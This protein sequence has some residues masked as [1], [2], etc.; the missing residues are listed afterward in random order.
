M[1]L[2]KHNHPKTLYLSHIF[3][4]KLTTYT[5]Q[6]ALYCRLRII[7]NQVAFTK[8]SLQITT[9]QFE[10]PS[11]INHITL[12]LPRFSVF[13]YF[14]ANTFSLKSTSKAFSISCFECG[15]SDSNQF[16]PIIAIPPVKKSTTISIGTT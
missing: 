8:L 11:I 3:C 10:T 7:T 13:A 16:S 6:T 4:P 9:T 2:V 15:F 12:G 1:G 5:T 14:F